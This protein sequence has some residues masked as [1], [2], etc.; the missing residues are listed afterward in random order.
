[1]RNGTKASKQPFVLRRILL[2]DDDIS[3]CCLNA[4]VLST[5]GYQV[6][7]A[8]DGAAGWTELASGNYDLLI[9]DNKMPKVT[10]FELIKK[11]RTARI[12][13]PII[14]ATGTPPVSEFDSNPLL[15]PTAL[16]LKPYSISDLLQAVEDVLA[17]CAMLPK[18]IPVVELMPARPTVIP[19]RA[20]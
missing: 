8:T 16:L 5:C 17:K 10:G 3:L 9:T 11:V 14:M 19:V 7:M 4:E 15:K 20:R 13:I 2:V 1:M 6:E 12:G 18:Q